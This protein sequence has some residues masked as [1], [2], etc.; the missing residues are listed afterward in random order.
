MPKGI[1]K[2]GFRRSRK[3]DPVSLERIERE[4]LAKIPDFTAKLEELTRD[5]ICVHCGNV[6]KGPDREAL[7]YL[8]NRALGMPRQRQELDITQ[9]IQL[10][11][12]QIEAVIRNHLPRIVEMYR[13][14][15]AGLLG[16]DNG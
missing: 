2:R 14:E 10:D 3:I 11:A 4:L 5:T 15:I 8:C 1:P 13:P 9:T 12:D 7:I 6:V 16:S